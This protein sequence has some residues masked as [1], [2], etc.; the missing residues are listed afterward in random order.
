VKRR[1]S[2]LALTGGFLLLAPGTV[3]GLIPWWISH[4]RLQP[5]WLGLDLT[6]WLGAAMAAAGLIGLL[7]SFV[8]FAVEG[9]G[10]PAPALPTE[11]LIV[12]GLYRFVRNPMYVAVVSLILGQALILASPALAAYAAAI[13]LAFHIFVLAYEEPTLRRRFAEPYRRYCAAVPRWLPRL[14]AYPSPPPR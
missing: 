2:A 6:R 4:W 12:R 1:V 7:E 9:L 10:T 3:A 13:W 14:T 11:R 5:A 8:R